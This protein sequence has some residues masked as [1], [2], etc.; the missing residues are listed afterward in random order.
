[1]NGVGILFEMVA[2]KE[3]SE[4]VRLRCNMEEQKLVPQGQEEEQVQRPQVKLE[5]GMLEV[6]KMISEAKSQ[7]EKV[8]VVKHVFRKSSLTH[9]PS[10]SSTKCNGKIFE[11]SL[12]TAPGIM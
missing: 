8:G 5:L 4:E 2:R 3:L 1:M 7:W 9:K 6:R 12:T 10:F 11:N